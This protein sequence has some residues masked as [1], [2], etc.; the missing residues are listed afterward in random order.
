MALNP[1]QPQAGWDPLGFPDFA[2]I[3][4]ALLVTAEAAGNRLLDRLVQIIA[5]QDGWTLEIPGFSI[6]LSKPPDATT[7]KKP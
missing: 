7:D 1:P 4:N 6:R 3:G 5:A 2:A